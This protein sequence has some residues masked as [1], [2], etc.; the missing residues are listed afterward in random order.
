MNLFKKI[1][2]EENVSIILITH[3][4]EVVNKYAKQV[5][6]MD[7]GEIK[8]ISTCNE[9]F[10][11]DNDLYSLE[12]PRVYKISKKLKENGLNIN[13][14]NINDIDSLIKEIKGAKNG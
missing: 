14:E 13:L 2:E 5:I 11:N 9:L 4:M 7:Q 8:S 12:L 3:D 10:K 1:H 6:L